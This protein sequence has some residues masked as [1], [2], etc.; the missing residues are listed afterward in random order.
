MKASDFQTFLT[1]HTAVVEPLRHNIAIAYWEATITGRREDFERYAAFEIEIQRV[2]ANHKEF[3]QLHALRESG[4]VVNP[5]HARALDVLYHEY[6]RHQADPSLLEESMRRSTSI[7]NQ[8]NVFRAK[9]DGHELTSNGVRKVLRTS[10][11]SEERRHVWEAEKRVGRIVRDDL[12]ELVALRNEIA[13]SLGFSDYYVMSL[14]LAEQNPEDIANLFDQIE[15]LTRS[16]FSLLKAELDTSLAKRCHVMPADLRPW[17]YE[18]PFFQEAPRVNSLDFD[19][20]YRGRDVVRIVHEFYN[21]IGLNVDDVIEHSDLFEKQGK[22]QHAYCMDMDRK[23]DVRVLANVQDDE[24]WTG[25]ML[26]ELGHAVYDK[27]VSRDLPFVL[28]EHAHIFV[29][30]AIAM[31]FGR[32]S[33]DAGWISA[34]VGVRD[35]QREAVARASARQQRRA[36]L[37][38]ARWCQVMVRFERK[39]YQDPDGDLNSMW[40]DLIHKCQMVQPPKDRNEPDW[41]SKIHIVSAPVYYH[42]YMLGE[43]LASQIDHALARDVLGGQSGGR[44]LVGHTGVGAYLQERLFQTGR[45]LSWNDTVKRATG[46]ALN[47]SYFTGQFLDG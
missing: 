34:V 43:L 32:L 27:F 31:L 36:Q 28:R 3:A 45:S 29:T 12:L 16:P 24:I 2:Y 42:N 47:P 18:D 9:Y 37:V 40:W 19:A 38:F 4:T 44:A 20:F 46:E 11:D 6:Q 1:E 30:E 26:H 39:L 5:L 25:T 7:L 21:G 17:H 15:T 14:E 23:G 22:E 8:F 41:A 33:K 10:T 13:R 35:D